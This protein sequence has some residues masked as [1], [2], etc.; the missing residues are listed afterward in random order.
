MSPSPGIEFE[1]LIESSPY[2]LIPRDDPLAQMDSI[3]LDQLVDRDMVSLSLPITQ[4]FF[5][6][7]F[8]QH[9]LRPK[10]RHQT[11]SYELVR[12]L[13]GAGEGYAILIMRPVNVRA[14]DGSELAYVPLC[15]DIPKSHFGLAFT[16]QSVPT[17]LVEVFA[18]VCRELLVTEKKADKYYVSSNQ[19]ARQK[20]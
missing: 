20:S 18:D 4:Q 17:R 10:I 6:S 5:L 3:S 15:G 7:L 14:Y 1:T 13:V 9:N 19:P 12:S 11:K 2:V 8:A 16:N